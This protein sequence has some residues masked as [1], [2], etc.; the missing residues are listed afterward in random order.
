MIGILMPQQSPAQEF[1]ENAEVLV[2]RVVV[3]QA[4]LQPVLRTGM[5]ADPDDPPVGSMG[6]LLAIL[7]E[8]VESILERNFLWIAIQGQTPQEGVDL[9]ADRGLFRHR[10]ELCSSG[11]LAR[12]FLN[13]FA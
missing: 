8:K 5:I 4:I 13:T 1:P 10:R 12:F 3:P 2:W 6:L 11:I 7:I 9:L